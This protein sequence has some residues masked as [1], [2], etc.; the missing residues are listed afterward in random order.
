MPVSA[1][2]GFYTTWDNARQTFGEGTPQTGTDF[3]KS[4]QL[5]N[6]GAGVTAAAPGSAWSGAA[7]T[8]YDKANTDHQTAFTRLAEL[9]RK[10]ARQVDQSAQVVATGR[11][12]LD[13]VRQWVTDAAN[14]VPPGKQRDMFLMQ[15]A[16]R[17]L[18]QLSEVV[19]KTNAESNTVAQDLKKLGP[20]FDALT[21]DQKF[22]NGEKDDK[23]DDVDALGSEEMHAL[24]EEERARQDVEATLR[25]E[26]VA[27]G[28]VEEVLSGIKPGE[29]LDPLQDAYLTQMQSQQKG[30]DVDRLHE[31]EQQLGDHKNVIGD[32]WQLMSN[33]DVYYSGAGDDKHG[34]A[35]ALPDSVQR[36]LNNADELHPVTQETNGLKY[37]DDLDAISQIVKDGN[38]AFQTGTELD[39]QMMFAADRAMDTLESDYPPKGVEST[40]QGLFEAVDDDHQVIHDHMMGRNGADADDFLRDVNAIDWTDNGKAAGHLFSW[41]NE[42]STGPDAFIASEVAEKYGSYIGS[43]DELMNINGQTL[44]EYNPELVKGYAHGLTPYISDIAGLSTDN[45]DNGFD[46]IDAEHP[47]ERPNAKGIFSVLS[48][49]EEAYQ[50]FHSAAD[51]QVIA[52]SHAWAEDIKNGVHV[53]PSDERLL[54]AQT[55]KALGAVGTA[56]AANALGVNATDMYEQQKAAYQRAVSI[57]SAGSDFIP[58]YGQFLSPGIDVFGTTMESTVIGAPPSTE[59]F[60]IAPLDGGEAARFAIN[61]LLADGQPL[62]DKTGGLFEPGR[63]YE[64]VDPSKPELGYKPSILDSTGLVNN[65]V[66]ETVA[67]RV[68]TQILG[69]MVP[70]G[71]DPT[72]AMKNQYDDT[73]ANPDPNPT[74]EPGK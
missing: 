42:H 43:H 53:E 72:I 54:D 32:S 11:Q 41:T 70:P 39:R 63:Y 25:G 46:P 40:V 3:D 37:G 69:D 18:A 50:E 74:K 14:S 57:L 26:Q 27:A 38:P 2:D 33:D 64:P 49:Q 65:G 44:G 19:Q 62:I 60:T 8:N 52:A 66:N 73:I 67:E 13:Q 68:L 24:S 59:K 58:G 56:E 45:P 5:T 21:R 48:T 16:N 31:V 1:L 20:E 47:A 22:G 28:R 4:P 9:D 51:A 10:I 30:M 36:A 17:G 71:T 34:T 29:P 35:A 15:I 12:N 23:G 7:A 55:L 61:A 6:L